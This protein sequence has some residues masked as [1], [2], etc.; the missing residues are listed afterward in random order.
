[1]TLSINH[2]PPKLFVMKSLV[3]NRRRY[4]R[5]NPFPWRDLGITERRALQLIDQRWLS[6]VHP[7]ELLKQQKAERLAKL[8]TQQ[9]AEEKAKKVRLAAARKK[10]AKKKTSKKAAE[11]KPDAEAKKEE[12]VPA[13]AETK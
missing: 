1:M 12:E 10:V 2:L 8:K 5:G 9:E 3:Q 11:K 7:D 13:T 6:T 4:T